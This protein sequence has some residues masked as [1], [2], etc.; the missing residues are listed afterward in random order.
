MITCR[1][2]WGFG[3]GALTLGI[4]CGR[5]VGIL[6]FKPCPQPFWIKFR[7]FAWG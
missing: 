2:G 5:P 3:T 6:P 1:V 7:I 4:E